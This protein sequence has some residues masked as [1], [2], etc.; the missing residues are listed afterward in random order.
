[1]ANS[2]SSCSD[3]SCCIREQG[4]KKSRKN[5]DDAIDTASAAAAAATDAESVAESQELKPAVVSSTQPLWLSQTYDASDLSAFAPK[6]VVV[7]VGGAGGNA[8]T[9]S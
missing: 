4:F 7:G 9:P 6:I 1:M 2:E 8:G 5:G 3:G